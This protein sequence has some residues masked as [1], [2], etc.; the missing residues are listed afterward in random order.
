MTLTAV[1]QTPE[2]SASVTG[3]DSRTSIRI[4][5][6]NGAG[7]EPGRAAYQ[8]HRGGTRTT[9]SSSW[10]VSLSRSTPHPQRRHHCHPLLTAT[11]SARQ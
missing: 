4:I 2:A 11:P 7:G 10:C 9:V 5:S 6:A 3:H 1:L 8:Q